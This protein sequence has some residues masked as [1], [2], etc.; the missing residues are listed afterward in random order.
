MLEKLLIR[1]KLGMGDEIVR[2]CVWHSI[3]AET[4]RKHVTKYEHTKKWMVELANRR[5]V[6]IKFL[7]LTQI[8]ITKSM[9]LF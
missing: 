9:N 8:R 6:A 4:L 5:V 2:A 7:E 3:E 1:I